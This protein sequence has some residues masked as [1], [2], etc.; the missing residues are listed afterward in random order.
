MSDLSQD[1]AFQARYGKTMEEASNEM[2]RLQ[3]IDN[4]ERK[5]DAAVN[6]VYGP[7][8]LADLIDAYDH[9]MSGLCLDVTREFVAQWLRGLSG[10]SASWKLAAIEAWRVETG[11]E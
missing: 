7:L 10:V 8:T 11:D 6:S 2:L 9:H 3:A 4:A 5:L 1:E